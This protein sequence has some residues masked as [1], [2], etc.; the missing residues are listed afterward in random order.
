MF[1]SAFPDLHVTVEDVLEDGDKAV[2]RWTA[3]GT[4]RGELM[5]IAPTE[6]QIEHKGIIRI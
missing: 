2:T 1:L 3:C 5:G 6:R 4:Q